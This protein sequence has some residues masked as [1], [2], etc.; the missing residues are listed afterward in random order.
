MTVSGTTTGTTAE[1]IILH[2][3]RLLTIFYTM[4]SRLS[5]HNFGSFFVCR[6][7]FEARLPLARLVEA[8]IMPLY[9]GIL[10]NTGVG[11]PT[12]PLITTLGR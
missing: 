9:Y 10:I 1:N 8:E 6:P 3:S 7:C 12:V 11:N 4:T 5:V 2:E